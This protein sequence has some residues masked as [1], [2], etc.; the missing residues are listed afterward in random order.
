[1][2]RRKK[3]TK[4]GRVLRSLR[5]ER[6]DYRTGTVL[7]QEELSR[8]AGLPEQ[9][10]GKIER[11]EQTKLDGETLARLADALAL[12]TLERR[13]FFAA[14]LDV[15]PPQAQILESA[16][17]EAT[18]TRLWDNFASIQLPAYLFTP[19]FDVLGVNSP[20]MKFHNLGRD[21]LRSGSN[22]EAR[23]NILTIL[24]DSRSPLRHTMGSAWEPIALS[25]LLHFR[26]VSLR[27]RYATRFDQLSDTLVP[28]LNFRPFWQRALDAGDDFYS[29]ARA[30]RYNHGQFGPVDYMVTTTVTVYGPLYLSTLVPCHE[31]TLDLFRELAY[32]GVQVER[33]NEHAEIV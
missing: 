24:F 6:V 8:L 2:N 33:L 32:G 1:M 25:N 29:R 11:G 14:A 9:A 31:R 12:T 20:M 21:F 30:F 4:F 18:F 17:G 26:A 16:T 7:S 13:E 22:G 3:P 28:L 27:Y 19:L 10:V 5:K 23:T 15:E